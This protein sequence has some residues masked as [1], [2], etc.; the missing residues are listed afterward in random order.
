MTLPVIAL[1]ERGDVGAAVRAMRAGAIDVI[2]KP[3]DPQALIERIQS[4]IDA[5]E[6]RAVEP[7]EGSQL[8]VAPLTRRERQVLDLVAAGRTSKAIGFDLGISQ[9]TVE[10]H[11]KHI[12]QKLHVDSL[13]ELLRIYWT[14]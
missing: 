6:D 9:K 4:C 5:A 13:A 1:A 10:K 12:M 11:R 14:A 8:A 2:E 3:I 7:P